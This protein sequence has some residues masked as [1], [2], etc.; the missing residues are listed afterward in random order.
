M[1]GMDQMT[2]SL[3]PLPKKTRKDVVLI[4]GFEAL[5]P[6]IE[7]AVSLRRPTQGWKGQGNQRAYVAK[8]P[9]CTKHSTLTCRV[10]R[11]VVCTLRSVC[12]SLALALKQRFFKIINPS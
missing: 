4:A 2:F 6:R 10:S 12:V 8:R 11:S 1:T 9:D 3:D 5:D 7:F